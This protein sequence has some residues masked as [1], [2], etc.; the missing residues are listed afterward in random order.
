MQIINEARSWIGTKF[1]HQGR[2]KINVKDAGGCD[3]LGLI[4][5]LGI[6]TNTGI[7]LQDFDIRNYP[8]LLT[9]NIL[10]EQLNLLLEP[11]EK[12]QPGNIILLKVNNWPQHLAIVTAVDPY[13][14]I[15]HSYL[16]AGKVLEQYLPEQWKKDIIAVYK[17]NAAE[18]S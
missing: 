15:I 4:L 12:L 2:I 11:A 1:K 3:C 18:Q 10:L 17:I 9:S 14:T 7:N 5:G 13:I 6:K 8:K 16:Q